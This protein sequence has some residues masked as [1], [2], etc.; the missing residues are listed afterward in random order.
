MV[1]SSLNFEI[2][3]FEASD[4]ASVRGIAKEKKLFCKETYKRRKK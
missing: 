4:E 1:L 3:V 2:K